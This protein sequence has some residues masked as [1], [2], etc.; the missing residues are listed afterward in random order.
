MV[1]FLNER[2]KNFCGG[3]LISRRHILTA[4]HCFDIRDW[5]KGEVKLRLA[6]V[7]LEERQ[8]VGTEAT[9]SNVKTHEK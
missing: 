8:E 2:D 5:R 7:D 9:I 4:A 1:S 3:V 6:Q